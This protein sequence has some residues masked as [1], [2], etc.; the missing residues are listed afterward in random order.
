MHNSFSYL[1]NHYKVA[2]GYS[3]HELE[4][5]TT[6]TAIGLGATWIERHFTLDQNMWGSDQKASINPNQLKE[7]VDNIRVIEKAIQYEPQ[8][9]ILFEKENTK[10]ISLRKN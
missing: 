10:K 1:K 8:P 7:L 3:G 4:L 6:Y 9:R 5:A 2:I